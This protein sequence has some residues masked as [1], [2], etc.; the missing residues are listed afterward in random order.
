MLQVA[1][2]TA[3]TGSYLPSDCLV[4]RSGCLV[5]IYKQVPSLEA[6]GSHLI[7]KVGHCF[8][9]RLSQARH[10][11]ES[12]PQCWQ[13]VMGHSEIQ[14]LCNGKLLKLKTSLAMGA[15][16]IDSCRPS[17]HPLLAK[18]SCLDSKA[19]RLRRAKRS[20]FNECFASACKDAVQ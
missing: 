4:F 3:A 2:A 17:R 9:H 20:S 19:V 14:G 18:S 16:S 15:P 7:R 12:I 10:S 1:S 5:E 8:Q 6:H 11:P 13:V